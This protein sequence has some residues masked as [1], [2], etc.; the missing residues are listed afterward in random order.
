MATLTE[1]KTEAEEALAKLH[2]AVAAMTTSEEWMEYLAFTSKLHGYSFLNLMWMQA[3][4]W[5]RQQEDPSLPAFT[6][7]A[8]FTF[9][10][11]NGRM[12]RKGEK[13]LS[14]LAPIIVTDR[15]APPGPDGKPAK[16]LI[17]FKLKRRTFDVSQTEGDDIP[18]NPAATACKLVE[19]E[20][21]VAT[22]AALRRVAK[23]AGFDVV[24][25][26]PSA[27][28][29]TEANGL[30]NYSTRKIHLHPER[31]GAQ[32]V[33]TMV[34]ELAH[35]LMHDP[36]NYRVAHTDRNSVVETEAESVAFVVCDRLG[37]DSSGYSIGYV[38]SWSRGDG[39]LIANTAQ[40]VLDCAD[41]ILTALAGEGLRGAKGPKLATDEQEVA[42]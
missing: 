6:M 39:A 32:R 19:G 7:P 11:D 9:W 1:Q 22:M 3:Q 35:A 41:R 21:D 24:D 16:K 31:S 37:L 27:Y 36:A 33:K 25:S 30:C 34:H 12:V 20:G 17:G 18:E 5:M 26:M 42:A 14:V 2:D 40:R 13:A 38:A 4:W 15:E 23:L 29:G 28:A 8:S 10:K